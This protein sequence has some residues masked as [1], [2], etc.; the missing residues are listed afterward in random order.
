[1]LGS[2]EGTFS[3]SVMCPAFAILQ[4]VA[5]M[6]KVRHKSV[7]QFIGACTASPNLCILFEFMSGGS[8]HDQ[9]KKVRK[10]IV[11]SV[12]SWN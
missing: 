1:M 7:V 3:I 8:V 9:L 12:D 11:T 10:C 2:A 6:R 5:I 4:E